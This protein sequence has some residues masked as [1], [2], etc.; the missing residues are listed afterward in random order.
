MRL[1]PQR[2]DNLEKLI[3]PLSERAMVIRYALLHCR[4][5][6]THLDKLTE[7]L[8]YVLVTAEILAVYLGKTDNMVE[9]VDIM[10]KIIG[11]DFMDDQE[12]TKH[13]DQQLN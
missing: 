6:T 1:D 8:M 11:P 7:M 3:K 5:Y 4:E 10:I 12:A 13:E 2:P 9:M